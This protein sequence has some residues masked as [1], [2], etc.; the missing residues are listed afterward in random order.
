ML[1]LEQGVTHS[2]KMENI[3]KVRMNRVASLAILVQCGKVNLGHKGKLHWGGAHH[4]HPIQF[5]AMNFLQI[6]DYAIWGN[7]LKAKPNVESPDHW[8]ALKQSEYGAAW[9]YI[10]WYCIT[11][12]ITGLSQVPNYTTAKRT[13]IARIVPGPPTWIHIWDIALW[14]THPVEI[15]QTVCNVPD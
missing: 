5:W 13:L 7:S 3:R 11:G 9:S 10:P 15:K 6:W 12:L 14:S 4:T 1:E 8:V 2:D